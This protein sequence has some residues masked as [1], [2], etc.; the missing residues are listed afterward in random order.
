MIDLLKIETNDV[1]KKKKTWNFCTINYHV[2][3]SIKKYN[4]FHT[5]SLPF[6]YNKNDFEREFNVLSVLLLSFLIHK[7]S[8]IK[9]KSKN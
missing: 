3:L 7:S 5:Q 4:H 2:T 9:F 6:M 8:I 1:I